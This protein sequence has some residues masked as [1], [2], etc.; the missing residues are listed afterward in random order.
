[1]DKYVTVN[2]QKEFFR[3]TATQVHVIQG[4][5]EVRNLRLFGYGLRLTM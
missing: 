4:I 2:R 1:M 5:R 3:P